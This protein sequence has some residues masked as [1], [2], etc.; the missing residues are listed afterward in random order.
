[1]PLNP[2][3]PGGN[4]KGQTDFNKPVA[5]SCRIIKVWVTFLL[6]S[7]IKG[8][9]RYKTITSQN[10]SSETQV[11]NFFCYV[12]FSRY[13]SFCIFNHPLIYQM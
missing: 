5:K 3:M 13:S 10:V 11:K 6:P 7:G 8:Y 1:M 4:K 9:L 12:L 2:L